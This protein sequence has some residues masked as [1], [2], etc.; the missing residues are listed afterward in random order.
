MFINVAT[1]SNLGK[2]MLCRNCQSTH[3]HQNADVNFFKVL[4]AVFMFQ[5]ALVKHVLPVRTALQQTQ[6][7]NVK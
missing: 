6:T 4:C 3:Y 2:S 5:L 1:I 7:Q